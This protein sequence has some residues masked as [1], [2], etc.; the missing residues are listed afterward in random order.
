[1]R[2]VNKTSLSID[3]KQTI[4]DL[5]NQ[6]YPRDLRL[7]SLDAFD[8]YLEALSN[9]NH[10]LLVNENEK[11]EGWL[12]DFDRDMER[13]FVMILSHLIHGE[14]YGSQLLNEAKSRN[15]SLCGWVIENDSYIKHDKTNYRSPLS[16]YTKNEFELHREKRLT[17]KHISAIKINWSKPFRSS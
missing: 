6:E 10:V 16:F 13:W 3:D 7:D 11:I 14:G 17:S 12:M 9:C 8:K 15:T 5:W 1:M 4:L 2:I